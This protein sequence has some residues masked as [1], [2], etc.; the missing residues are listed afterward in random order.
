MLATASGKLLCKGL[1][2]PP[3]GGGAVRAGKENKHD[4]E[5]HPNVSCGPSQPG[6]H[7][8]KPSCR[9]LEAEDV[10]GAMV[11]SSTLVWESNL[12]DLSDEDEM[13]RA[14]FERRVHSGEGDVVGAWCEYVQWAGSRFSGREEE[15]R[16][17]A[18][19]CCALSESTHFNADVRHLRLWVRHA[20]HLPEAHVVFDY[21]EQ[22]GIGTGHALRY[23]AKAA[24][25]ERQ[26]FFAE[27]EAEYLL[28]M[29]R[30]AEP[31][32]RLQCRL[33]EFRGRMRKRAARQERRRQQPE[34]SPAPSPPSPS[35]QPSLMPSPEASLSEVPAQ[36]CALPGA[37]LPRLP[38][39]DSGQ[40]RRFSEAREDVSVEE[41]QAARVLARF[42][43]EPTP[44]AQEAATTSEPRELARQRLSVASNMTQELTTNGVRALLSDG[45][46][47]NADSGGSPGAWEDPTYTME[48]AKR[49]VLNLLA[50]DPD[51]EPDRSAPLKPLVRIGARCGGGSAAAL[52]SQTDKP[53]APSF[54][55]FEEDDFR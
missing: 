1:P 22:Q 18:R 5:L 17:L 13:Q 28:G 54:A 36:G 23:E 25:L 31:Q 19:A 11:Q 15:S 49:E 41:L 30:C 24:A 32:E 10:P 33:E 37:G 48:L 52:A 16:L 27:A 38:Q 47:S 46:L 3:P 53:P 6:D 8:V 45:R 29:E 51:H 4:K 9:R 35:P 44:N 12:Q 34:A 43:A 39:F 42:S 20:S 7:H 50:H 14:E 21:L 55:I 26:H 40:G 2:L